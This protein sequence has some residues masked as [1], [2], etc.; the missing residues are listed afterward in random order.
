MTFRTGSPGIHEE[1]NRVCA[2]LL[3][4]GGEAELKTRYVFLDHYKLGVGRAFNRCERFRFLKV[5]NGKRTN[6][7]NGVSW[8]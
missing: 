7:S 3:A 6:A 8:R 5:E 4:S 2:E 1:F